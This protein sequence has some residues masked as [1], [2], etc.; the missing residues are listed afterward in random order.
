MKD[1][2]LVTLEGMVEDMLNNLYNSDLLDG[3]DDFEDK[4]EQCIKEMINI[5]KNRLS[6][7]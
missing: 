1:E 6:Y 5:L 7:Y 3:F 2:D 4:E